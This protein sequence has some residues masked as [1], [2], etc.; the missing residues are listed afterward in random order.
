MDGQMKK[1]CFKIVYTLLHPA[2]IP[3]IIEWRT[4]SIRKVIQQEYHRLWRN[5]YLALHELPSVAL[6]EI[7]TPLK[8]PLSVILEHACMPPYYGWS[9]DHD[10]MEAMMRLVKCFDPKIVLE[11]GTAYG[12]TVANICQNSNAEVIT[13]NAL[14]EQISGRETTYALNK[15][16][17]GSVYREYGFQRR[18]TQIFENTLDFNHQR[19]FEKPCVDFAIIDGCHDKKFV[20]NDFKKILPILNQRATVLFHDTHPSMDN[21]LAGSYRACVKLR[22]EGF[23]IRHIENTWWAI[24]QRS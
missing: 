16:E 4:A 22:R 10:D 11:I 13:I 3:A 9:T 14:P 20:V 15:D 19:Y 17:I 7:A 8:E 1:L 2:R 5:C 23:D 24:W 6:A 18:V 12:N 21:H